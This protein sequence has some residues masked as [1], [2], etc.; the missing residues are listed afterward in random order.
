MFSREQALE[1]GFSVASAERRM[2][3]GEW[4]RVH[5]HV[6]RLRGAPVSWEQRL[7]AAHLWAGGRTAVSHRSAAA[8]WKLD[9][10]GPGPVELTT[11]ARRARPPTGVTL[12]VSTDLGRSDAGNLGAL[13]VTGIV[14]TLIDLGAVVDD[15]A[16]VEA[17]IESAVRR[18]PEV[19]DRLAVRL[20]ALGG[21][22]RRGAGVV[23]SILAVRDPEA[24]ASESQFETRLERLLRRA[25]MPMP[26]RQYEVRKQD[27]AFV[28]RLD[29]AWPERRVAVEPDGLRW[30]SG[31]AAFERGIDRANDLALS[32]W[33]V[34]HVTWNDL[35]RPEVVLERLRD[36]GL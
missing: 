24:A 34:L 31:R 5:P 13:R 8:L 21:H 33:T 15:A 36:A 20:D 10:F 30:H 32:R 18:D 11:P 28:A 7:M 6:Y 29:F 17:A 25:R 4:Q 3:S 27:G 19:L 16:L 9:G 26:T 23:R 22:G 35:R 1:A 12:H 2:A 14:R